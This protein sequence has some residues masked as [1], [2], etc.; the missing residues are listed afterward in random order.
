MFKNNNFKRVSDLIYTDY[1]K[2]LF[3]HAVSLLRQSRL[4]FLR[5][6]NLWLGEIQ[7]NMV[8]YRIRFEEIVRRGGDKVRD[9]KEKDGF[10]IA[11]RS[12]K[13]FLRVLKDIADGIA[14]RSLN[15]NRP[16]IRLMSENTPNNN[17]SSDSETLVK[18]LGMRKKLSDKVII[19][20]LTHCLKIGDL[21][22]LT[23]E[24]KIIVYEIK[25]RQNKTEI[26][27]IAEIYRRF[28]KNKQISRQL[29]KQ[30]IVQDAII[31]KKINTP[32]RKVKIIDLDFKINTHIKKIKKLIKKSDRN[33]FASLLLEDGYHIEI[34]SL[35]RIFENKNNQGIKKQFS[36]KEKGWS[37]MTL[38]LSNYDTFYS[39]TNDRLQNFTPY[40]ILPFS[41][42]NCVRLMMGQLYIRICFDF[43]VLKSKFEDAGWKVKIEDVENINIKNE[44]IIKKIKEG[45]GEFLEHIP[46]ETIFI[47]SKQDNN[48]EYIHKFSV[49]FVIIMISSF[50]STDY[51]LDIIESAYQNAKS[52]NKNGGLSTFNFVRERYVLN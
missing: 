30:W 45:K 32:N 29:N 27:G 6:N 5:K 4:P 13:E 10:D 28:N 17:I 24:N 26:I 40:S 41:S 35:D 47:L 39:S 23:S 9:K 14:W 44:E 7:Q 43:M 12:N 48:G 20:D 51:L 15:Y 3:G 38:C 16:I 37:E 19:N 21:T 46:D 25:A 31:N 11:L 34:F 18:L 36:P 2:Y 50:Y 22:V 33:N 1:Y 8:K 42:K 52:K 49:N